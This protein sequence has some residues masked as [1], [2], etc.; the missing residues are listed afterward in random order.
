MDVDQF[1]QQA[2]LLLDIAETSLE[3]IVD[4]MLR[5][6][7]IVPLHCIPFLASIALWFDLCR[8]SSIAPPL[9]LP[10]CI[11]NFLQVIDGREPLTTLKEAKTALFTHDSGECKSTKGLLLWSALHFFLL[12]LLVSF[13]LS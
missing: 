11:N 3:G 13:I 6:V 8:K 2:V 5:K 1:L 12:P 7:V 10:D 4:R 9:N